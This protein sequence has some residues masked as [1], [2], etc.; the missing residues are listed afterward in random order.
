LLCWNRSVKEGKG[1]EGIRT[2]QYV[3]TW[4]PVVIDANDLPDN[5][6]QLFILENIT[7]LVS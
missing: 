1:N 5:I 6:K 7:S 2:D 3:E 4:Q